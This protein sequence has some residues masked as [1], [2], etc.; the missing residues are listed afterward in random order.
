MHA[1]TD[2]DS[3]TRIHVR[4][5]H[6]LQKRYT[7][8]DTNHPLNVHSNRSTKIFFIDYFSLVPFDMHYHEVDPQEVVVQHIF[9]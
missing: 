2:T 6:Y 8:Q 4:N 9:F 5:M 7:H 1:H 3:N